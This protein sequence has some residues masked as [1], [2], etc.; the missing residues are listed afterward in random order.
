MSNINIYCERLGPELLAEP[1]NLFTNIAFLLAAVLLLKQL[2]TPNKHIT[3][4]IGLLFIIGIGSMLFHSFA[5]SWA[6]FLDVLPI[7][8]FQM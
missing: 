2:S 6:R 8:L 3:G 7:L 1:I 4:L 5:T